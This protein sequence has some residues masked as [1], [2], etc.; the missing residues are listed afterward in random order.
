MNRK[1]KERGRVRE[2]IGS[3][4]LVLGE[5]KEV[6]RSNWGYSFE[7]ILFQKSWSFKKKNSLPCHIKNAF[8]ATEKHGRLVSV[9]MELVGQ[10]IDNSTQNGRVRCLGNWVRD[11]QGG[12]KTWK[13]LKR[14][15][16]IRLTNSLNSLF[17]THNNRWACWKEEE[18]NRL[19]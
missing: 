13:A 12:R 2:N 11:H 1:I 8:Y 18:E 19:S 4:R 17:C 9:M 15:P 10:H 5:R 14:D 6:S 7:K 3:N 16:S